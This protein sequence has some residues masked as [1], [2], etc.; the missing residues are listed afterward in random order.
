MSQRKLAADQKLILWLIGVMAL[1]IAGII[2]LQ[3]A[4]EPES[5]IP[6]SDN[7][8]PLG[9][10]AAYLTLQGLGHPVSRWGKSLA[11]LNGSIGDE[12]ASHTTLVLLEPQY[13]A[14][15]EAGL[16]DE[17]AR[18]L[19]RGGR[20]LITGGLGARM[21]GAATASPELL[22]TLCHTVPQDDS[23][24]ARTGK[25]ETTDRGGWKL[26]DKNKAGV[27]S[28]QAS[29]QVAQ[30]CGKDEVVVE[31][32]AGSGRAVWW[33]AETPI[34]NSELKNDS[35]L[36]L[37]LASVDEDQ[38]SNNAA[39]RAIVFD[40][41]MHEATR[42]KWTVTK[43]LPILWVSLQTAALCLL[44]LF[45]F[46]RRRGPIR[47][48]VELPRSSPVEFATSMGDLYEKGEATGA[49]TEA[50]RRR[51]LRALVQNAGLANEVVAAGPNAVSEALVQR[52]GQNARTLGEDIAEHLRE[53]NAA[54]DAKVSAKSALK[55][56]QA[57]SED[58]ERLRAAMTP[59]AER[60][61]ETEI[62]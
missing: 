12:Q 30:K 42:T 57:L 29:V 14:T 55:L 4:Q 41:A 21:L 20:M 40:E 7:A 50:A 28:A 59:A 39:P 9:V 16:R 25:V 35:A 60:E 6:A 56:A 10:K 49:V 62:R 5:T 13:D 27:F 1:L 37:L 17:V 23:V 33:T 8:G 32:T 2:V 44:L 58:I 34:T 36:K 26:D 19:H 48:A 31:V 22:Q 38:Y 43:G 52:L 3:P 53:A 45:S 18:F 51:L 15:E 24:L 47:T 54:R 11:E 61:L 46:S